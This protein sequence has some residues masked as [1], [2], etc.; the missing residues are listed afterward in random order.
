MA[1]SR[2]PDSTLKFGEPYHN[3]AR[4]STIFPAREVWALL[5]QASRRVSFKGT[6]RS[7]YTRG[8][9]LKSPPPGPGNLGLWR[10]KPYNRRFPIPG[11][12]DVPDYKIKDH[13]PAPIG[14]NVVSTH[15]SV[16]YIKGDPGSKGT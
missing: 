12:T 13:T 3:S 16:L 8:D 14:K 6:L 7:E 1:Y 4:Q 2:A 15:D 11:G 5:R 9:Q 10:P